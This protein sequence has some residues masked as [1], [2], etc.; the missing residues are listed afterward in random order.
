MEQSQAFTRYVLRIHSKSRALSS[1]D[2]GDD[3]VSSLKRRGPITSDPGIACLGFSGA[4]SVVMLNSLSCPQMSV[5][6]PQKKS[7]QSSLPSP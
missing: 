3:S 6:I 5:Y 1:V 4:H 2:N 7:F